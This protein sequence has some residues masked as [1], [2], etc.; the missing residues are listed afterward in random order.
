VAI[1]IAICAVVSIGATVFLPDY[2]NQDISEEAAY[3]RQPDTA[4]LRAEA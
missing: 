3:E 1:Y 4:P 2:T